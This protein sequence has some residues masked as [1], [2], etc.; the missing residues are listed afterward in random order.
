M[1]LTEKFHLFVYLFGCCAFSKSFVAVG[2]PGVKDLLPA[3][4]QIQIFFRCCGA[5]QKHEF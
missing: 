1:M 4:R 5:N 3:M 2:S